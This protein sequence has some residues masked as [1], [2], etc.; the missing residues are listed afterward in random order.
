MK[1]KLL[2]ITL[3][4]LILS[5]CDFGN[6]SS[7]TN[8]N[9]STNSSLSTSSSKKDDVLS[10][11]T[12]KKDDSSTSSS[13]S[14][15][16]SHTITFIADGEV[17]ENVTYYEG[18][19]SVNEP[20][21]PEKEGYT[22]SWGEYTLGTNDVEVHAIYEAIT[23]T[24]S[25]MVEEELFTKVE[26]TIENYLEK[27][28]PDVP[29]RNHYIGRWSPEVD[30]SVLEDRTYTAVYDL[31]VDMKNGGFT[32]SDNKYV[33]TSDNSLAISKT[34]TMSNG[35]LSTTLTKSTGM[36]DSGIVFGVTYS[37]NE[38]DSYW[39]ASGV[40][41]YYFFVNINNCA[42]LAKSDNGAWK[43][44]GRVPSIGGYNFENEYPLSV[45]FEN[46][47]IRCFVGE[48]CLIKYEDSTPLTG[49]GVGY[50]AQKSGTYY[51]NLEVS[52]VVKKD[53]RDVI[54]GYTVAHG[55][56]EVNETAIRTTEG[57]TILVDNNTRM[58]NG[59]VYTTNFKANTRQ[60]AGIV[61][62]LRDE[63]YRTFWEEG[64]TSMEYYF[65]FINFDGIL[66]LSKVGSTTDEG[67]WTTVCDN[68]NIKDFNPAST[69]KLGVE[70]E[71]TI[72]KLY[73]D[74]M[75]VHTY[76]TNR[77]L[78]GNMIGIRAAVAGAEF[79]RFEVNNAPSA[80]E[81]EWYQRSGSF[82]K[83]E[84]GSLTSYCDGSL[85]WVNNRSL[86]KGSFQVDV[87]ASQS[88]DTGIV[89]GCSDPIATRW[90][91]KPYYFFFVNGGNVALLAGPVNG[92]T[93]FKDGGNVSDK[94]NPYGTP[95]TL[96]VEIKDEYNIVCYVNGYEVINVTLT[97]ESHKL[98][99]TYFGVRCVGQGLRK[100][101]NF[102][103]ENA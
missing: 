37:E 101:E 39:E 89:F 8:S 72:L 61:I 99:G 98:T 5:G 20:K 58:E 96:K 76:N 57:N 64:W 59:K 60:D 26:Y 38:L 1:N 75:L 91:E 87:T 52:E 93:T 24:A 40:S 41:Y 62:G 42:Y 15:R 22:G 80:E 2:I 36:E 45:S 54:D 34:L 29:V 18:D 102:V 23:Y 48:E 78:E 79:S 88:S 13:T 83:G 46:G 44:L 4:S 66:I 30:F 19:I 14:N 86:T 68:N 25:F 3:S 94:L 35:T 53:S 31:D 71:G 81:L 9:L 85:A 56:A 28:V 10:S 84:D 70:V 97:E 32:Y 17:V 33:A 100:F 16:V 63:G 51:T 12:S 73:V 95:N 69:Y 67:I 103:I 77:T 6:T 27:E 43:Q 47:Y 50:R 90:E 49:T 21:V 7:Q 55:N 65:F 74:G 82:V 92:W 11:S